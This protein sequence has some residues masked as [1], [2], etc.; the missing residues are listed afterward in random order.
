LE[1]SDRSVAVRFGNRRSADPFDLIDILAQENGWILA[2][3]PT[4]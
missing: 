2:G 4:D 3:W 1:K